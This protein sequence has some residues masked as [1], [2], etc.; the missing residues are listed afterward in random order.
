MAG[1]VVVTVNYRLSV[2]GF[3]GADVLR[4]RDAERNTTGN[5]GLQDQRL[6]MAW[7]RKYIAVFGGDAEQVTIFGESAGA[8]SV[9]AHLASRPSWG[10]F[11]RAV[12]ESGSF[13][14]WSAQ[15]MWSAEW[16]YGQVLALTGCDS[17]AC[18]EGKTADELVRVRATLNFLNPHTP[19]LIP[20]C[21]VVD[22]VELAS[23]PMLLLLEG[24]GG[25][26]PGVA[27][28]V[29]VMHGTNRDEG[30][31]FTS[32]TLNTPQ[33]VLANWTRVFNSSVAAAAG[34]LYFG[35]HYPAHPTAP[36]AYWAAQRSE[37]D[38]T[39]SCPARQASRVLAAQADRAVWEYFFDYTPGH[40]QFVVHSAELQ[41]VWQTAG[42]AGGNAALA[43]WMGLAWGAFGHGRAPAP[44]TVW[45]PFVPAQQQ[46]VHIW[47]ASNITILNNNKADECALWLPVVR[48]RLEGYFARGRGFIESPDGI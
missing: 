17:V 13:A 27:P 14:A 40:A 24:G 7:V 4:S 39:F 43:R 11:A 8:G 25:G 45:P 38:Y 36:A 47:D 20:W 28:G 10:L 22:G 33:A 29:A 12:M 5:Y 48:E 18:L 30:A 15:P 2:F 9:S 6:G 42:A 46:L 44:A 32:P 37:G 26:Q 16:V 21:P 19:L 34:R 23:H 35:Q 3:L 31:M 1:A 41:Y